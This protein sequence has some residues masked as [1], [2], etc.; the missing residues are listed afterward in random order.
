M[1]SDM[2]QCNDNVNFLSEGTLPRI[3][4]EGDHQA[5]ASSISNAEVTELHANI[6][7][8]RFETDMMFL[9]PF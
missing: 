8:G 3:R 9:S 5:M 4:E 6:P 1:A 7:E 2:A